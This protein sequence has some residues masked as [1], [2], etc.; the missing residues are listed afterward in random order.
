MPLFDTTF[1]EAFLLSVRHLLPIAGASFYVVDA[2]G[3][4]AHH[5]LSG[6]PTGQLRDYRRRFQ[7]ED[8]FHPT[9]HG[10][11]RPQVHDN[12][13]LIGATRAFRG[14]DARPYQEGFLH[15]HGFCD[16]VELFFRDGAG[17]IA[18][19]VGLFRDDRQGRF[20]ASDHDLLAR[21]HSLLD[22]C[23]RE[24]LAK[25]PSQMGWR[26]SVLVRRL[27][28]RELE[29]TA[30]LLSGLSNKE[31]SAQSD[32]TLSTVKAHLFRIYEKTGASSR[33]D[34]TARLLAEPDSPG[35]P[36]SIGQPDPPSVRARS[37]SRRVC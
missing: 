1:A 20:R 4:P 8:P 30:L 36:H 14:L 17:R 6:L 33:M 16:E 19:G 32:I 22:L 26:T 10:H 27:T 2:Q 34:L 29:I 24:R 15:S 3:N 13:N 28:R 7:H 31:I 11:D 25:P 9:R 23:L 21:A 37:P 18:V 12:D 5:Q 35:P